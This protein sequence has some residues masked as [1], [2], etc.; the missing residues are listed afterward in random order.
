MVIEW[1]VDVFFHICYNIKISTY[2]TKFIDN[3]CI[4][5]YI[6]IYIRFTQFPLSSFRV[7]RWCQALSNSCQ[8]PRSGNRIRFGFPWLANRFKDFQTVETLFHCVHVWFW[9]IVLAPIKLKIWWKFAVLW[10]KICLTDHNEILHKSRQCYCR[11]MCKISLWSAEYV[12]NKSITNF[13]WISN[14]I[15]ILLVGPISPIFPP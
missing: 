4:K 3:R 14:S 6:V 13:Q 12:M 10:F 11:D 8:L 1:K 15:E 7:I 9:I 5:L 2:K